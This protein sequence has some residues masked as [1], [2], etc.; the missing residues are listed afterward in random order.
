MGVF[1]RAH[2]RS[3]SGVFG[4]V[5]P[6]F[7]LLVILLLGGGAVSA[8]NGDLPAESE[9]TEET[10]ADQQ[11]RP[12][13]VQPFFIGEVVV[14]AD[15]QRPPG[16]TD[17]LEP[18]A[19]EASGVVNAAQALELMPGVS[20]STG[21][22]NEMKIWVRGYEQSNVLVL[23][24]G[25]PMADP[26]YGDL[27]LGQLP[28][29]DIAGITVTRGGASPLYGPN[30]LGG[31]INIVTYQGGESSRITGRLRLTDNQTGLAHASAGG[32]AE[33]L[34]WY[35][36]L[37]YE[38][39]DGWDLSDGFEPT[40]YEDGGTRAN[41]DFKRG[42]AL[43]RVGYELDE[44][45]SIFASLRYVDSQKGIPFHTTQPSGFVRFAR[46]PTW[47]QTALGL[48]YERR[49]SGDGRLRA[50]LF[51]VGFEN[52]LE[53]YGDPELEGLWLE[54]T[55]SDRTYGGYVLAQRP[56]NDRHQLGTAL[57]IRNDQHKKI[58]SYPDGT[59][60][61]SERYAA[62][63]LSLSA[64][65]RWR[66][67][68]RTDLIISLAADTLRVEEARSLRSSG[69][70]AELVDDPRSKDTLLSPQIEVQSAFSD[71]WAGSAAIYHR[72]RF[73]T[74]RQL[75]GTNP[76]SPDLQPERNTGIDLGLTWAKGVSTVRANI[77]GDRIDDLISR[78]GRAYPY[79]NQDEAEIRG[80]ELRFDTSTNWLDCG[81][82]WTG[83]DHRF[84]RSSEGMD[85]I[86]YVPDS[87]FET[88]VVAHIGERVDLRGT[89]LVTGN[90]VFYDR[91]D[92]KELDGYQLVN[93]GIMARLGVTELSVQ[94]DNIFDD[95][96]EQE[97]GYP[98]PGRRIWVGVHV[99]L[100]P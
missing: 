88:L 29:F 21:G 40:E 62:W 37:G 23:V 96:I 58:E 10:D 27:D 98:L 5:L 99:T 94:A 97:D 7:V 90:R 46:F 76:P 67:G 91:G 48:A 81:V 71:A 2:K 38:S 50:Q 57:H 6:V 61:P 30:G 56:L 44:R 43:V 74:M 13:P 73:P 93:L 33:Q 17:T 32:G 19:I 1:L 65:D 68:R 20:T 26:Y 72:S 83:L 75:Y 47:Q 41:S 87:Q 9:P 24:D 3:V 80:L 63:T 78:Q 15:E 84:T 59:T 4:G 77:F 54:S 60:D 100:R 49:L 85:K 66:V 8:R 18:A 31:V 92:K 11:P 51:G 16:T 45:S 35:V 52:T 55:F 25:V 36:G 86:P 22:R 64:E 70:D 95:N 34:N 69:D 42:S 89:W 14:S 82:S 12:E 28:V 53:V 39:S 79:Q